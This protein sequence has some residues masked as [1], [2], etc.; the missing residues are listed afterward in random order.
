MKT[1]R[2]YI[3]DSENA[4]IEPGIRP[5]CDALNAIEGIVTLYSC[6]GHPRRP[7]RPYVSF[8]ASEDQARLVQLALTH[9][10]RLI[11]HWWVTGNFNRWGVW[12]YCLEPNDVRIGRPLHFG[13]LP[14]WKRNVMDRELLH[15]AE[16]ITAIFDHNFPKN[17]PI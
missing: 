7:A 3:N 1:N 14:T 6:E 10:D 12:M 4:F 5:L 9:N 13:V 16:S 11:Y 2:D 15:L 8:R 17:S